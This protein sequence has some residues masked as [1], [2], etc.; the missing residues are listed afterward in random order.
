[1]RTPRRQQHL[2]TTT[3]PLPCSQRGV[4]FNRP[5]MMET[6]K[7]NLYCQ[8]LQQSSHSHHA[9]LEDLLI[10]SSQY[11]LDLWTSPSLAMFLV[12]SMSPPI[13]TSSQSHI[14]GVYLI[15]NICIFVLSVHNLSQSLATITSQNIIH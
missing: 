4:I 5:A 8:H 10:N 12:P 9:I 11:F 3:S 14:P 6:T 7:H 2:P 1:M 15:Y 13:S